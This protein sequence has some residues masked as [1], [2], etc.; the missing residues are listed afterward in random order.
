MAALVFPANPII[1]QQYTPDGLAHTY[2][3][4]G[5]KWVLLAPAGGGVTNPLTADLDVGIHSII[6][7]QSRDIRLTPNGTGNVSLGTMTFDADQSIGAPQNQY[8][9]TYFSGS[10]EIMLAPAPGAGGG[11]SWSDPVDSNI[12]P[13]GADGTYDLGSTAFRFA[14]LHVDAIPVNADGDVVAGN[15][16][17]GADQV[18]GAGQDGYALV[19]SD[20]TGRITLQPVSGSGATE[21]NGL[22]D[23]TISAPAIQH[24][25][26]NNGAGQF[27]NRLLDAGDL[28]SG[29]LDDARVAQTN[30]TQHQAALSITEGQISDLQNYLLNVVEDPTPELGGSLST[31]GKQIEYRAA[32]TTLIGISGT[33]ITEDGLY[34]L[35]SPDGGFVPGRGGWLIDAGGIEIY[36]GAVALPQL[37]APDNSFRQLYI[38][39]A[40]QLIGV[41]PPA[42]TWTEPDTDT[43]VVDLGTGTDTP[44]WTQLPNLAI[45]VPAQGVSPG[46]R[47]TVYARLYVTNKSSNQSGDINIGFGVDGAVP[48]V[49]ELFPIAGGFAGLAT[50]SL[51]TA[52]ATIT[53]GQVISVFARRANGTNA[54]YGLDLDG[55]LIAH[56]L[57]VTVEAQGGGGISDGD[58][59]DITVSGAG[60]VWTVNN[61]AITPAK[62]ADMAAWTLSGR[63]NAA[64]GVPQDIGV[65]DISEQLTPATGFKLLGWDGTTLSL[66]DVGNLPTGGGGEVNTGTNVGSGADLVDGPNVGLAIPIRG[67][68][69][70]STRLSIAANVPA[71]NIDLDVVEANI[72]R[73]NLTGT[74]TLATISDSGALA[75][76]NTVGTAQIDAS[77][78]TNTEL[79]NMAQNLI[80]GRAASSGTGAPVD[81]TDVQV[82]A[83]INVE[84]GATGDQTGAEIK[85]LYEA[86]ANTNA[87]TDAE[88]TNLGNQSGTN[89]GDEVSATTTVEGVAELA[90]QGEVDGGADTTRIV[91]P[92]TLANTTAVYSPNNPPPG[93]AA[94]LVHP[95][96]IKNPAV[97][98]VLAVEIPAAG[99]VTRVS[100]AHAGTLTSATVQ[101]HKA[102]TYD[103]VRTAI[104]SA[105]LTS[106]TAKQVTTAFADANLAQNDSIILEVTATA[107]TVGLNDQVVVNMHVQY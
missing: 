28:Q 73:G 40:G 17:L 7:D 34:A 22:T 69:A 8:V 50:V 88:K 97:G 100:A 27:V 43:A 95:V 23:V 92:A 9:L 82:R 13:T 103:G 94:I 47:L 26:V 83:I 42:Q 58:K 72:N 20:A 81:L 99:T 15:F 60:T 106:S 30:V 54:Q 6:S 76:L 5:E 78:V 57:V 80:K 19:Y 65:G 90:T 105:P 86:E 44:A 89:T 11:N 32:D 79:A 46:E 1:G 39:D 68:N 61:G 102:A 66:A 38:D 4:D 84:D 74:Q 2:E 63:N 55:T 21:L 18:V 16:V 49:G 45:T 24:V 12:V 51:F 91:T 52:S 87:F 64:A 77:A 31:L 25:L 71:Q 85:A 70:L 101:L 41:E 53:A 33:T 14:E 59:G 93:G 75:A 3:W 48:T 29:A 62:R 37:A 56:E 67:L 107:G 98:D 36:G 35:Y 10:D 96:G 104:L